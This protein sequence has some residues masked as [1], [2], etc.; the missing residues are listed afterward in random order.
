ME[1]SVMRFLF[2]TDIRWI[3]EVESPIFVVRSWVHPRRFDLSTLV[4]RSAA[5]RYVY[6]V[7]SIRVHQDVDDQQSILAA[8]KHDGPGCGRTINVCLL[9]AKMEERDITRVES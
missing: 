1:P 9:C 6:K 7:S 3:M 8:W 4:R 2:N 5:I